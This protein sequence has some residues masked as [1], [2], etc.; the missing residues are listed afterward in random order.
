MPTGRFQ[1]INLDLVGPLLQSNGCS[2]ILTIINQYTRYLSAI[3]V[4]EATVS[5][6]IDAFFH[7][8]VSHF[9]EPSVIITDRAQFESTL[10]SQL[11]KFL[12]CQRNCTTSF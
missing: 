3:P 11:L 12:E 6:I 4:K 9:G 5:T 2:Y 8:Y 7:G 1:A 10:F